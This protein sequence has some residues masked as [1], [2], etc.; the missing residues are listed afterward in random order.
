[1]NNIILI[2]FM[3]CGKSCI[4]RKLSYKIQKT[5]IDID[6]Q[7]EK[8][9]NRTISEIFAEEGE[10]S[11]RKMETECLQSLVKTSKNQIISTGG[12]LPMR[13][14]NRVLLKQLGCVVFLR[15]TAETIY[16]RLHSDTT[17]PLLQGAEPQRKIAE[18]LEMR[19][20][21]YEEAADII[22]DVDGK[23]FEQILSEIQEA[24]KPY[25]TSDYEWT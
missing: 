23:D 25:E 14:E 18:L 16:E 5:V 19:A 3:G 10:E 1:M 21:T 7:I 12:G 13:E 22:I 6:K 8:E 20:V 24:L 17:R 9:Q 2:G 15:V 11:F 4:G